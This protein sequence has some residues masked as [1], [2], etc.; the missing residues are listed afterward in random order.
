MNLSLSDRLV[1][2]PPHCTPRLF[3]LNSQRVRFVLKCSRSSQTCLWMRPVE[4]IAFRRFL[5]HLVRRFF[6][7][8]IL[9][10][11]KLPRGY[12][13]S[14]QCFFVSICSYTL[15]VC[16]SFGLSSFMR[17]TFR[18]CKNVKSRTKNKMQKRQLTNCSN[19]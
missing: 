4:L 8:F 12:A 17:T 15:L 13:S 10:I 18:K 5:C 16:W 9:R 6:C 7:A 14:E 3:G 11:S 2:Y 1:A 19:L